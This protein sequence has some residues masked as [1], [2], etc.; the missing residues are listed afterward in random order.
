MKLSRSKFLIH[1][2]CKDHS[3]YFQAIVRQWHIKTENYF[4]VLEFVK[5][6]ARPHNAEEPNCN[7]NVWP[8]KA[9][10]FVGNISQ[11]KIF[12]V[13]E[14]FLSDQNVWYNLHKLD[15]WTPLKRKG[16]FPKKWYF[17]LRGGICFN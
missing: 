9:V 13:T 3:Y 7:K 1:K 4:T 16:R 6:T 5:P 15:T 12:A 8:T 14:H 17:Y 2:W 11:L 10:W